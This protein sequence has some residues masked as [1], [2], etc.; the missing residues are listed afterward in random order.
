MKA[1]IATALSEPE[2]PR[3]VNAITFCGECDAPM[4]END[5]A[6]IDKDGV[7]VGLVCAATRAG[8]GVPSFE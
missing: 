6:I 3:L 4:L 8:V 5:I 7:R 1:T 2:S